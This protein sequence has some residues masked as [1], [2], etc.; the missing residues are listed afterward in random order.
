MSVTSDGR[1]SGAGAP[2]ITRYSTLRP[3][4]VTAP[5]LSCAV[6]GNSKDRHGAAKSRYIPSMALAA[7]INRDVTWRG[8]GVA[9][10][11]RDRRGGV[12]GR[13]VSGAEHQRRNL[14]P[15]GRQGDPGKGG[16][17]VH[18]Q[19]KV[20]SA[21]QAVPCLKSDGWQ[22]T[23]RE[24]ARTGGKAARGRPEVHERSDKGPMPGIS[25]SRSN[26]LPLPLWHLISG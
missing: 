20:F 13:G 19:T 14:T 16:N 21:L 3:L 1:P 15:A 17:R 7:G 23:R 22:T 24:T 4:T 5:H 10:A 18:V 9:A 8:S 25:D 6:L 11:V 26:G 2:L 12:P